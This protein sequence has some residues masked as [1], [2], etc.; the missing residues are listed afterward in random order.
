[1]GWPTRWT[2]PHRLVNLAGSR[3]AGFR[4]KRPVFR[5]QRLKP[6]AGVTRTQ[7][8]A[9]ELLLELDVPVYDSRPALHAR[10]A[11][12]A[13]P[14]LT[15]YLESAGGRRGS[16]VP[17][18]TSLPLPGWASLGPCKYTTSHIRATARPPPMCN[19]A[20]QQ[21]VAADRGTARAQW[22]RHTSVSCSAPGGK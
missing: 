7:V 18:C 11:R 20:T 22:F 19:P 14:A 16:C 5:Q 13:L 9:A 21:G 4:Q 6:P 2:T 10:F 3:R 15:R 1:M 17:W 8:V 12:V